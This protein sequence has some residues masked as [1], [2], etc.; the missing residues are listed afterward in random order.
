MATALGLWKARKLAR[1]GLDWA[2]SL[3]REVW[4]LTDCYQR[5][6]YALQEEA[7]HWWNLIHEVYH[8][9]CEFLYE[10]KRCHGQHT[11][12][13]GQDEI[14]VA[15]FK[16]W[17]HRDVL[18]DPEAF[19]L[20]CAEHAAQ[21]QAAISDLPAFSLARS[22][23]PMPGVVYAIWAEDTDRIKIG[24]SASA[25]IRLETFQTASPFPL[26]LLR[27][28]QTHDTVAL[29]SALHRRYA[30]YRRHGEWFELPI[31]V[32]QELLWDE[33]FPSKTS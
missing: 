10:E 14:P 9:K 33:S 12:I 11:L 18:N 23:K 19:S 1:Y 28:I 4:I 20:S 29:E 32:Q 6:V 2:H 7:K 22:L 15:S 21:K 16:E 25:H 24:R 17:L 27:E 31:R 30:T 5:R 3:P 26:R 13:R 8:E